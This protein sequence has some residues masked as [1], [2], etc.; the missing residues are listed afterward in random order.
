MFFA[1]FFPGSN[2]RFIVTVRRR[3]FTSQIRNITPVP[4]YRSRN[5]LT[6]AFSPTGSTPENWTSGLQYFLSVTNSFWT[7]SKRDIISQIICSGLL[8]LESMITSRAGILETNLVYVCKLDY[9]GE[10]LM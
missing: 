9:M 4:E 5:C 2:L 8:T 7:S 6:V 1:S 3:R 10:S